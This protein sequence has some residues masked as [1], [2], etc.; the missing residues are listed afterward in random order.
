MTSVIATDIANEQTDFAT[1]TGAP[2]FAQ[3]YLGR[4]SPAQPDENFC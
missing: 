1:G 2:G 3:A 4:K